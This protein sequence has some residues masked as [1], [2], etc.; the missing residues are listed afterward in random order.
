L[1][2]C[3]LTF[4]ASPITLRFLGQAHAGHEIESWKY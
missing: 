3:L 4:S 2:F 1:V